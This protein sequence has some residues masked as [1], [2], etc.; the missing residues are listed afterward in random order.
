M[1][2]ANAGVARQ[3]SG[4]QLAQQRVT[5]RARRARVA[6]RP[7]AVSAP[8]AAKQGPT[9][10]TT[11][12]AHTITPERLALVGTLDDFAAEQ[13]LPIL[14]PVEKCWQPQD[15]LPDP[16]SPEFM[17]AVME[18]RKSTLNTPD[19][20]YVAL[21][22]DMITEEA[23]PTYMA[24]LNTLDG[25]R[26]TASPPAA[27]ARRAPRLLCP[28]PPPFFAALPRFTRRTLRRCATRRARRPAP[29]GSGRASG[30]RRRTATAT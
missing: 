13:V 15:F 5:L 10:I 21:I 25:V 7:Q 26:P 28:P 6:V 12:L 8:A 16:E 3:A 2:G 19:E 20:Y 11:Q 18:L 29:G 22:G 9:L 23:L 30:W 17:D 27:A 24:M 4:T 14:K 1:A